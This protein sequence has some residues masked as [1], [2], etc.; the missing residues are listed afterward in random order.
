MATEILNQIPSGANFIVQIS[1]NDLREVM[2]SFYEEERQRIEAERKINRERPTLTRKET[3]KIL[4]VTLSTLWKWAQMGYL[5]PVKIG[6]RVMY[7]PTDVDAMLE[8]HM[9]GGENER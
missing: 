4:G 3:A 9:G 8:K 2:R 5:V 7:R 6:T 1:A